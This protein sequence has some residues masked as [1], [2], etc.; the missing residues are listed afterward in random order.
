MTSLFLFFAYFVVFI[1]GEVFASRLPTRDGRIV[2]VVM[3][4]VFALIAISDFVAA[5]PGS[6]QVL[7]AGA[8]LGLIALGLMRCWRCLSN[9]THANLD[10]IV[11]CGR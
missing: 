8:I 2:R 5:E 6:P 3:Y 11:G 9:S 7:L 10:R 4:L 1:V